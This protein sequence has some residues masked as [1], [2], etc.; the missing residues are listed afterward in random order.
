LATTPLPRGKDSFTTIQGYNPGCADDD[1][2][3]AYLELIREDQGKEYQ[4]HLALRVELT[5]WLAANT[6]LPEPMI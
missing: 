6:A 4:G 2:T 3:M 5:E 1:A